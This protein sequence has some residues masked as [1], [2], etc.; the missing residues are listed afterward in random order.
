MEPVEAESLAWALFHHCQ[1][2]MILEGEKERGKDT[3]TTHTEESLPQRLTRHQAAPSLERRI[4]R[5]SSG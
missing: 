2:E 1:L 4:D 5:Q 3:H